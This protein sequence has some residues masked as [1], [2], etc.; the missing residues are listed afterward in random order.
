MFRPSFW[1][2]RGK[3]ISTLPELVAHFWYL[4][5]E[6]KII[7]WAPFSVVML[8]T[9]RW[10]PTSIL[11]LFVVLSLRPWLMCVSGSQAQKAFLCIPSSPCVMHLQFPFTMLGP[12]SQ[13]R[14][15][16]LF[17][18]S[19]MTLCVCVFKYKMI[20]FDAG[21]NTL[22]CCLLYPGVSSTLQIREDAFI[23]QML[24]FSPDVF[25]LIKWAKDGLCV[26]DT[27]LFISKAC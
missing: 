10:E 17:L 14:D 15:H 12:L 18:I 26:L 4:S 27:R 25:F 1:P 2:A 21:R 24:C 23:E 7:L 9:S 22:K 8:S 11:N 3:S 13:L 16:F 6:Y 5:R 20:E 19:E